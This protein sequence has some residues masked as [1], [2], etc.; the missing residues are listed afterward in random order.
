MLFKMISYALHYQKYLIHLYR[1][2]QLI[3]SS[4]MYVNIKMKHY[5]AKYCEAKFGNPVRFPKHSH[6]NVLIY[7]YLIHKDY[8]PN[9]KI[10]GS[11]ITLELPYFTRKNVNYYNTI[12]RAGMNSIRSALNHLLFV[13]Y[14]RETIRK[15]KRGENIDSA[16]WHFIEKYNLPED[17]FATF[18]KRIQ[19]EMIQLGVPGEKIMSKEI[20]IMSDLDLNCPST[21][22]GDKEKIM[23]D[24][25]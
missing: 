24:F 8:M 2:N 10:E 14:F 3:M 15:Y 6:L 23:S 5:L 4:N 17:C 13:E 1:K 20:E 7:E 9:D 12:S 21:A 19:R 16:I 22:F 18:R 11:Y 25:K